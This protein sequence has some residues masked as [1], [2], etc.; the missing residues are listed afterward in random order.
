[1]EHLIE[2]S[3]ITK[4]G[5]QAVVTLVSHTMPHRC[6]YVA[7][8]EEHALYGK[9]YSDM[10]DII[11]HGG[12]TYSKTER[13]DTYPMI[14]AQKVTWF[15]FDAVHSGDACDWEAGMKLVAS[16]EDQNF[17][18][19]IRKI[20]DDEHSRHDTIRT[21]EYM[22]EQCNELSTQLKERDTKKD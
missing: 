21:L 8:P 4:E 9:D 1:M 14:L 6:G 7:V 17:R 3:W 19:K 13:D 12:L 16:Q 5:Y 15:G 11:V 18:D 10:Y 22:K 2:D 20:I